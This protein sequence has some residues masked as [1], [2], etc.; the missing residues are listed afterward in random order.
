[1]LF[2]LVLDIIFPLLKNS[3]YAAYMY[4][5]CHSHRRVVTCG[6]DCDVRILEG[7]ESTEF[8]VSS[9]RLSAIACYHGC[10]GCD[11]VAVGMDDHSVQSF[12]LNVSVFV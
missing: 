12:Q 7:D 11:V 4:M 3:L 8:S 6:H 2:I 5:H 1:M 9:D 10:S